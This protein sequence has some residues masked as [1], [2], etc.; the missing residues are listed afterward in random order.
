M[1]TSPIRWI[2]TRQV[3]PGHEVQYFKLLNNLVHKAK[4]THGYLGSEHL[5]GINTKNKHIVIAGWVNKDSWKHWHDSSDRLHTIAQ[6]NEHL[7]KPPEDE[8][9][10]VLTSERH[11]G[12]LPKGESKDEFEKLMKAVSGS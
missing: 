11:F 3:K 2:I 4:G 1:A 9:F 6:L 5:W 10:V 12:H 8:I 7:E